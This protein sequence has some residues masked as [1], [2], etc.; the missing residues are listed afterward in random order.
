MSEDSKEKEK[1]SVEKTTALYALKVILTGF[2][3]CEQ[4]EDSANG[5]ADKEARIVA[6]LSPLNTEAKH[7]DIANYHTH[8]EEYEKYKAEAYAYNYQAMRLESMAHKIRRK[9]D[10]NEH[11]PEYEEISLWA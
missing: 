9:F 4:R 6:D 8:I 5:N 2:Q 1:L 7:K 3:D 10:V 11:L